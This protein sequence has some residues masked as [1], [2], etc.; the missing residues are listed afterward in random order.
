MGKKFKS[1]IIVC[2]V[3]F[4]YG[5]AAKLPEQP[6][7]N[8]NYSVKDVKTY[9]VNIDCTKATISGLQQNFAENYCPILESNIKLFLQ[10]KNPTWSNTKDSPE[11]TIKATLEQI[12]GGSSAARFW[13]GFGAGR[14]VTTVHIQ[15]LKGN[16][17]I[18]ERR[19]NET[20]TMPNIAAGNWT[21]EDAIIQDAP[22]IAKK[23]AEFVRNPSGYGKKNSDLND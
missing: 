15:V 3:L 21:N 16:V 5:C 18:A 7:V 23:I 22:L 17:A 2:I 20:T 11:L 12:H 14:S 1:F 10:N 19:F 9:S 13:V 6:K 4:I 8:A